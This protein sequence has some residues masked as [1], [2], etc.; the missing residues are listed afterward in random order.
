[1]KISISL[2]D[3]QVAFLDEVAQ[4][5]DQS[6]SSVVHD[7]IE[8]LR[9]RDLEQSYLEAWAPDNQAEDEIASWDGVAGDGLDEDQEEETSLNKSPEL[10]QEIHEGPPDATR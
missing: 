5:T 8:L 7:A 4:R 9:S 1:M 3:D 10:A 2:P 6:R